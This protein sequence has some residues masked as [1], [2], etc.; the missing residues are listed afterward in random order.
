MGRSVGS[1]APSTNAVDAGDHMILIGRVIDFDHT[2][3]RP[4]AYLRG[5]FLDLNLGRE[6]AAAASDNGSIAVGAVLDR[7]GS[8]LL[9]QKGEDWALPVGP[10]A[11]HF[12]A[13]REA[14]EALLADRNVLAELTFLYSVFDAPSEDSAR[15]V[16]RGTLQP[17]E[18]PEDMALFALDDLPLNTVSERPVRS[19]LSRYR[20]EQ[21]AAQ[22]GIYVENP[23]QTGEIAMLDGEPSPWSAY[24]R[25]SEQ[26]FSF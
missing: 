9:Q 14:F 24:I 4:L 6:A 20:Q 22:F 17:S 5:S 7:F 12:G 25:Q 2:P 16:F 19:L 3:R 18:L 21:Q 8:V 1:I 13:A 10:V 11:T 15:F 26:Q 23:G